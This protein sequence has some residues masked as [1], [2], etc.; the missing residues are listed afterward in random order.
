MVF[1]SAKRDQFFAMTAFHSIEPH[2]VAP[3]AG[4]QKHFQSHMIGAG[5]RLKHFNI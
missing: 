1:L 4:V 2:L 5:L 3:D